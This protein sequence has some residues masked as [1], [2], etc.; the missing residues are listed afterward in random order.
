[1]AGA[2]ATLDICRIDR[3][4]RERHADLAGFGSVFGGSSSSRTSLSAP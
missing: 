2:G 3:G 4:E 1:L